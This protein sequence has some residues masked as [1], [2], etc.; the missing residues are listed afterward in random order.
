MKPALREGSPAQF[1][2]VLD[3]KVVATRS[4]KFWQRLLGGG[5]PEPDEVVAQL[6]LAG[7]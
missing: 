3:G 5:W 6:R 1:D 4:K 2:V 7:A